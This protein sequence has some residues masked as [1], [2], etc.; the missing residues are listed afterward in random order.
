MARERGFASNE[1]LPKYSHQNRKQFMK[2]TSG[3]WPTIANKL[4]NCY[5]FPY[6]LWSNLSN[7]R[8]NRTSALAVLVLK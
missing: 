2:E 6:K 4:M 5:I 7:L 3:I 1:I 8:I